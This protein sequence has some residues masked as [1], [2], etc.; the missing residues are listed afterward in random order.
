MTLDHLPAGMQRT[1]CC[2]EFR[3]ADADGG[4]VRNDASGD[5]IN[6]ASDASG[7]AV[8]MGWVARR[9]DL[10]S[11]I[12]ID[13]RD[14][15]GVLQVVFNQE[16]NPEAH[17]RAEQLRSEFVIAVEGEIIH[18]SAETLNPA[19]PT[20]EVE[21]V[22]R[23][24]L[25]LN[26]A[27]TPPFPLDD[28]LPTAEE[29]RLRY[30]FIDLRRPAMQ[31]NLELRHRA[32][33]TVRRVLDESGFLEIETPFL[34]RSTP[35]GARDYL[36]PSRVQPGS[37]Y[38]LPQSPQLFKQ[39][40]MAGGCDRYFQIV[41]CFRDEDLRADRQPEFT[42]IDIEM[43]YAEPEMI[44]EV[45]EPLLADLWKLRGFDIPLPFPRM[46]YD[47]AMAGYGSDKP[48][49]R[50]PA[51]HPVREH[52]SEADLTKMG[53]NPQLPLVAFRVPGCGNLSRKE[54]DEL[55]PFATERGAKAFDDP[56]SLAKNFPAQLPLIQQATGFEEGDLLYLVGAAATP[57]EPA[58]NLAD[59]PNPAHA[60]YATAGALRLFVGQKFAEHHNLLR[61]DNFQFLWVVDFPMFEWD[62]EA[63]R[64]IAAHHPFTSPTDD[65]LE[66]L[67]TDAVR[68]R[69]RAYDI[70]LNGVELGSGSVRIHRKDM[71]ARI[72]RALG[73]SDEVARE[74]FGFF[75][76][77][78]EYGTPPHGGIALGL[79]RI[80]MILAGENSIREVIAFP[81]TARAMDPMC[82]APTPVSDAQLRE[83]GLDLRKQLD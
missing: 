30:R 20:G 62:P 53:V 65:T 43:T 52:F 48:E 33:L 76:D 56:K 25:I 40:L 42:Q 79:D 44:F 68:V 59:A 50:L 4:D 69:A 26:E 21:L 38:A 41:R 80:I 63:R 13:L 36:V 17:Q 60:L 55:R 28:E 7:A 22:A 12:F 16:T 51:M 83:L 54:R 27:R 70:V 81:K 73:M 71:Q 8:A 2:G 32:N 10:G 64:H 34:T 3:P 58:P 15:T 74:R 61:K 39:L 5:I 18:R 75:L 49:M 9:R 29:T 19:I 6:D 47:E 45:I 78:L 14:R 23:R 82:E 46:T 35:E 11:L 37:F 1:K 72:F 66:L 31:A 24:V 77:A 67:E 57:A